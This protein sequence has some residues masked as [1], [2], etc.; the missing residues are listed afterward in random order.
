M[1]GKRM[2]KAGHERGK[3][4]KRKR[5]GKRRVREQPEPVKKTL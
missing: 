4:A 3:M 2:D 1:G 5:R